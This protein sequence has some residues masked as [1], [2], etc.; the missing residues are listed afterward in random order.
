MELF[1]HR[2]Y[3]EILE[4]RVIHQLVVLSDGFLGDWVD[5]TIAYFFNDDCMQEL[6]R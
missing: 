4:H 5:N 3:P 2:W 1:Q 6:V